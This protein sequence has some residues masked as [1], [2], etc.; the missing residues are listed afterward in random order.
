[1]AYNVNGNVLAPVEQ[2]KVEERFHALGER[3]EAALK[4]GSK[5]IYIMEAS[6]ITHGAAQRIDELCASGIVPTIAIAARNLDVDDISRIRGYSDDLQDNPERYEDLIHSLYSRVELQMLDSF[7][8]KYPDQFIFRI[9]RGSE[10]R[11]EKDKRVAEYASRAFDKMLEGNIP[12]RNASY[13]EA[14]RLAE[15]AITERD[16]EI[17]NLI[18]YSISEFGNSNLYVIAAVGS[19]HGSG[20]SHELLMRGILSDSVLVN[21]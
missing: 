9:E 6:D 10:E 15:E 20:I 12:A 18:S 17:A 4:R 16:G 21:H 11:V 7:A 8:R 1:M 13:N 14:N 3:M 2:D 5:V 19:R